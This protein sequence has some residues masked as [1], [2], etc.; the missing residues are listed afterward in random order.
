[1]RLYD[2]HAQL[3]DR[4]CTLVQY[5]MD[6]SVFRL[7]NYLNFWSVF[8]R[9]KTRLLRSSLAGIGLLNFHCRVH[10]LDSWSFLKCP[11]DFIGHLVFSGFDTPVASSRRFCLFSESGVVCRLNAGQLVTR[12]HD[13]DNLLRTF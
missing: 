11:L 12:G 2:A 4:V 9:V 8:F 6:Q 13:T 3:P 5:C 10:C 1:M 7:P